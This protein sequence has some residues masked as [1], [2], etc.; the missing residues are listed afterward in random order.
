MKLILFCIS[1]LICVLHGFD[2][3]DYLPPGP[4]T[5]ASIA[6]GVLSHF[7]RRDPRGIPIVSLPEPLKIPKR[8]PIEQLG[9]EIWDINVSGLKNIKLQHVN[10]NVSDMS[11][12]ALIRIPGLEVNN[13]YIEE[14]SWLNPTGSEGNMKFTFSSLDVNVKISVGPDPN[15]GILHVKEITPAVSVEGL[16]IAFDPGSFKLSGVTTT[17]VLG[18]GTIVDLIIGRK[19]GGI[20]EKVNA[21][22]APR[23]Q[24]LGEF[25]PEIPA[26]DVLIAK[27]MQERIAGAGLDPLSLPDSER[28]LAGGYVSVKMSGGQVTGLSGLHRTGDIS[29]QIID[30]RIVAIVQV[31]VG[32]VG[33]MVDVE[34]DAKIQGVS[35]LKALESH[36]EVE[37]EGVS[38]WVEVHQSL[39]LRE[40][41]VLQRVHV[42]L[43]EVSVLST[44]ESSLSYVLEATGS[45]LVNLLREYL[46]RALDK[47]LMKVIQRRMDA[48]DVDGLVRARLLKLDN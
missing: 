6:E 12:M 28:S 3:K 39:D 8:L 41:M 33:V 43:G 29:V 1:C 30:D 46:T 16:D 4:L 34:A 35:V 47:L 42:E 17:F 23:L 26:I 2:I 5:K 40:K 32:S 31:G 48:I 11:V 36:L 25:P 22:L 18:F 14:T 13:P 9:V 44:G 20:M 24:P 45:G 19:I 21:R 10:L 27:L 37:V 38:V 15:T 7:Q